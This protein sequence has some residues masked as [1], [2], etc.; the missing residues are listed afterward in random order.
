MFFTK[1]GVFSCC[2]CF[3]LETT[4]YN[5]LLF[6]VVETFFEIHRSQDGSTPMKFRCISHAVW[7]DI[8][9]PMHICN[10]RPKSDTTFPGRRRPPFRKKLNMLLDDDELLLEI[11][12]WWFQFFFIFTPT[13]GNDPKFDYFFN[14][15]ETINQIMVGNITYK[16][17]L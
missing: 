5:P 12:G 16:Y 3:F 17:N 13:W 6:F 1:P 10:F 14:W 9:S 15:V 7:H 8:A 2:F 4:G 11:S